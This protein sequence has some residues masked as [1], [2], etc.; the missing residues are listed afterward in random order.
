MSDEEKFKIKY[1]KYKKKYFKL[2]E[3]I[4]SEGGT[5]IFSRASSYAKQ[6]KL[7]A[8]SVLGNDGA[9]KRNISNLFIEA[10]KIFNSRKKMNKYYVD[11]KS[12]YNTRPD[13]R[14]QQIQ[15]VEKIMEINPTIDDNWYPECVKINDKY[16]ASLIN[17]I[18]SETVSK[19]HS[20]DV[21]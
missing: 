2:K 8:Y 14:D 18:T 21:K 10:E 7:A 20:S 13:I 9:F 6:A 16:Q 4:E 1:L 5:P 11:I 19:A 15:D 3:L 12:N 17:Y